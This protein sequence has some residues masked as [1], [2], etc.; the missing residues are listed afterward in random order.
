[1]HNIIAILSLIFFTFVPYSNNQVKL[2]ISTSQ[3]QFKPAARGEILF[4]FTPVEGIHINTDPPIAIDFEKNPNIEFIGV[5]NVATDEHGYVNT[6]KTLA[7]KIRIKKE[8]GAGT[9]TVKGKIQYF[10]CSEIDGVCN[11]IDEKIEVKI[12]VAK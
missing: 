10:F 5:S 11:K 1:M 3:K 2:E 12:I 7:Y 8:T 4:R 9:Y 6:K